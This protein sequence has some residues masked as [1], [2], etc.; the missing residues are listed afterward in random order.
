MQLL[1]FVFCAVCVCIWCIGWVCLIAE[2]MQQKNTRKFSKWLRNVTSQFRKGCWVLIATLI[3]NGCAT[4]GNAPIKQTCPP[5]LRTAT[6]NA[7]QADE[8]ADYRIAVEQCK[9]GGIL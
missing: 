3:L 1:F 5:M 7:M 9:N 4:I 6:Y 2:W 8:L